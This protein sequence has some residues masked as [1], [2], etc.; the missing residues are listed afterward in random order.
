MAPDENCLL[1][2]VRQLPATLKKDDIEDMV[3]EATSQK[4]VHFPTLSHFLWGGEVL[5][6]QQPYVESSTE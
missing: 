5:C 3:E 2:L 4:T 6:F 1:S